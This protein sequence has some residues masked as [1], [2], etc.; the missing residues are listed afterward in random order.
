MKQK[1]LKT[2]ERK[3]T[4]IVPAHQNSS[5]SC[6][7]LRKRGRKPSE[8][9]TL[10]QVQILRAV[11]CSTYGEVAQHF[12]VSRQRIHQIVK[13]WRPLLPDV[14]QRRKEQRRPQRQPKPK[15]DRLPHVVSFR[16]SDGHFNLLQQRRHTGDSA[17]DAAREIVIKFLN[18]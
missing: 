3:T 17:N 18:F 8:T 10:R 7:P 11:Q 13:R 9:P 2:A 14:G 5:K 6:V 1:Q 15:K 12:D 16:V 4:A